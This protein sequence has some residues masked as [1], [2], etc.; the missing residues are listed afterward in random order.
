VANESDGEEV[1]ALE[2]E[3]EKDGELA[4]DVVVE[5]VGIVDEEDLYL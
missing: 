1:A 4:E 5:E 3:V 2:V